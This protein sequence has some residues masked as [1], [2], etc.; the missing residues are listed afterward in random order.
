[1]GQ[2]D[3][4]GGN[5]TFDATTGGTSILGFTG[6]ILSCIEAVGCGA[7]EGFA[8]GAASANVRSSIGAALRLVNPR[9][10]DRAPK[11]ARKS[12]AADGAF[13]RRA[14]VGDFGGPDCDE[15]CVDG[16]CA[17]W[18]AA[19]LAGATASGGCGTVGGDGSARMGSPGCGTSCAITTGVGA[20]AGAVLGF[21][22]E[23]RAGSVAGREAGVLVEAA[24]GAVAAPDAGGDFVG[25]RLLAV[26]AASPGSVADLEL[27]LE[28][29]GRDG[30]S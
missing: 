21:V 1:V 30:T 13:V 20:G 15:S 23:A 6:T 3:T 22:G 18:L 29:G 10:W 26:R 7:R 11:P 5:G 8:G 12:S 27:A 16:G 9:S 25:E 28:P 4:A 24:G 14:G 2:G 17:A 19:G